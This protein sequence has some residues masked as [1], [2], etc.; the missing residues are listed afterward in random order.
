MGDA[1]AELAR[2]V[3]P[4]AGGRVSLEFS[5]P[6]VRFGIQFRCLAHGGAAFRLRRGVI[7]REDLN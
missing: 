4:A 7:L 2:A 5:L 3:V 6:E 1:C